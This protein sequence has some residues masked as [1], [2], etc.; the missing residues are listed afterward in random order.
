MTKTKT[1]RA[2]KARV[3]VTA[4][5]LGAIEGAYSELAS[6]KEECES[7]KDNLEEKFSGT[8]KY[9]TLEATVSALE[10]ADD[11]PELPGDCGDYGI[12][13]IE[14]QTRNLSRAK[15]RDNATAA[16]S[17]AIDG[18]RE[19]AENTKDYQKED[20]NDLDE[21]IENMIEEAEQIADEIEGYKDEAD[22]AEFP[23]MYG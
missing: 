8:D 17:A 6:L 19:W 11:V 4:T 14:N 16:L 21:E 3:T 18:I 15:R 22:S 1:Q 5:V 23:G 20:S 13:Y 2:S 12:S 7:W 10:F 9:S